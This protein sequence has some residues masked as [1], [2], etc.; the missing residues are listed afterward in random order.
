MKNMSNVC[1]NNDDL[2]V[3]VE[4]YRGGDEEA[5]DAIFTACKKIAEGVSGKKSEQWADTYLDDVFQDSVVK[6]WKNF[7]RF[8]SE[9]GSFAAWF[10]TVFRNTL[11]TAHGKAQ[12]RSYAEI[13]SVDETQIRTKNPGNFWKGE[14]TET[15]NPSVNKPITY[16]QVLIE[17]SVL[18][19][20]SIDE[21]IR[22]MED[23]LSA[24][25]KE[26]IDMFYFENKSIAEI[27]KMQKCSEATVKSRLFQGRNK[28]KSP[29][30]ELGLAM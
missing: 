5:F 4:A 20:E 13:S 23:V 9:K 18:R 8:D 29:L 22:C 19:Q 27:A 1:S 3:L 12:I 6:A 2:N 24:E 26:T 25:Q 10:A 7:D 11:Y 16:D 15:C 28:L 14:C 21:L 30:K 17:D